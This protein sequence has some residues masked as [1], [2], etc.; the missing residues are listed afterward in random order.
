MNIQ[1]DFRVYSNANLTGVTVNSTPTATGFNTFWVRD[2]NM[3]GTLDLTG[4]QGGFRSFDCHNN[5]NLTTLTFDAGMTM[6]A[7]GTVFDFVDCDI[8]GVLDIS[9]FDKLGGRF[10]GYN[11]ANLTGITFPTSTVAFTDMRVYNTG[12]TSVDFSSL[13]GFAGRI[14]FNNNALTSVTFPVTSATFTNFLFQDN[15]SLGFIDFTNLTGLLAANVSINV[16]SI[17]A[18]ATQMNQMLVDL[19]NLP[20]SASG[21][22]QIV[23]DGTNAAPDGTSGGLDGLTAKANLISKGASVTTN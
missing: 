17:N 21:T 19:D 11:N 22:P 2:C 16:R 1:G 15:S 9:M 8:T 10:W 23:M 12:L 7:N 18:T 14:E 5:P 6:Y 20:Y 3:T 13:S 4:I